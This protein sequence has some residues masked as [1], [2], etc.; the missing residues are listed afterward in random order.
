MYSSMNL[1]PTVIFWLCRCQ[2]HF[3]KVM[4]Q[5]HCIF[6]TIEAY[7]KLTIDKYMKH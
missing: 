7:Q 5:L 1:F 3:Q 4:D 2:F 6:A